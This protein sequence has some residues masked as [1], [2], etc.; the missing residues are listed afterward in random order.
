MAYTIP[1]LLTMSQAELDDLFKA[2]QPG[3]IPNGEAKGTAIVAPGTSMSDEIAS[4]VK[5]LAWQGKTFDS[6]KGLL[7]NR[8]L[9]LG[10]SAIIAKVYKAP[11]W[12]DQKECI[13]LDYSETSL[14]A[15]WI[16]DEIRL[17]GPGMYLGKVY[18]DKK[19]LID[20]ALEFK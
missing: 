19:R 13:V 18:W 16:R 20:F 11:S 15:R 17:I 5:H 14:V 3:E 9:P 6:A 4:F 12:L 1:Q 8:I 2:S 10:L 7:R